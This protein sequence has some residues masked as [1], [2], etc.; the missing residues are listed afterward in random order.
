MKEFVE[1][2]IKQLVDKPE[3]VNVLEITGEST[4]IF[5]L[6]VDQ[7]DMGKV[8]GRSGQTANSLRTI[9]GAAAAKQGRRSILE[10][11]EVNKI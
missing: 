8:I 6:R 10:I 11:L 7:G 9:V 2:V 4:V 5:E 1:Y 3:E